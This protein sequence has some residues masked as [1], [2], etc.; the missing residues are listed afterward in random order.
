LTFSRFQVE[1]GADRLYAHYVQDRRQLSTRTGSAMPGIRVVFS[2]YL[3]VGYSAR[4]D[5]VA[6][7]EISGIDR[8]LAQLRTAAALAARKPQAAESTAPAQK[9]DFA[10]V[11]K[12]SL[13]N[14]SRVQQN[15]EK[16]VRDFTAGDPNTN[17]HD[18]V[19]SMQKANISFQQTVQVRNRLVQAYHDIMN[20][21]V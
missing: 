2:A 11:L 14:V 8:M 3:W 19:I 10:N 17:L 7:M 15:T 12:S 16:L 6:A 18:V 21:Q 13:D 1:A 4:A 20:M 9:T 5:I